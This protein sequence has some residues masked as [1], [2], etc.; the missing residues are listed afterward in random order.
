MANA[1][2]SADYALLNSMIKKSKLLKTEGKLYRFSS[3]EDKIKQTINNVILQDKVI[4]T[5]S[6]HYGSSMWHTAWSN[7][8]NAMFVVNKLRQQ[9]WYWEPIKPIFVR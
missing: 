1:G 3:V 2:Y 9:N 4:Q 7:R 5:N 6:A 8:N